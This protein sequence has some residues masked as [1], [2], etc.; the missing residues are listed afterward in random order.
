VEA[1]VSVANEFVPRGTI[2]ATVDR[3]GRR[4]TAEANGTARVHVPVVVLVNEFTASASEILA[5]AL[6]DD[7]LATLVGVRTFGKGVVQTIFPLTG[8]AGAAITTYKYLTP[9]GRS[10][11]NVGLTPDVPAGTPLAG[12]P[13]QE[14]RRIQDAQLSRAIE[15]LRARVS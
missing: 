14:M 3:D 12:K 1:A 4:T 10:I 11:H 7:R 8:G 2:V 6:Q 15:V 9:A 13:A 5:G